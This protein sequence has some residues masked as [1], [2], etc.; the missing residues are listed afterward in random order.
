MSK[1]SPAPSLSSQLAVSGHVDLTTFDSRATTGF[2]GKKADAAKALAAI[3]EEL[4]GLQEK[5]FAGGRSG[6]SPTKVLLVLQ[7]MDTSGK[8]GI[9]R[10]VAG[11]VDPQGLSITSFKKPTATELE[12]DFLWRIENA[13]PE[14]GMIGIFDRSHYE[15]VLIGKVRHLVDDDEISRRY[16]AINDFER[17]FRASG[18]VIVKCFLHITP[19]DQKERLAARLDDPTKYWKY[20]AGDLDERALWD[21]YQDA[22]AVALERCSTGNGAWHVVPSGRKW[23]RN[24][25]V[26]TLLLEQLRALD[27]QWPAADFDVEAEKARLAAM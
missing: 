5:L 19:D 9:V 27:L 3:G 12:H 17:S 13:L 14:P 8:G 25:A 1:S 15:D 24:W 26:A 23:Y 7:G 21:D 10:H 6:A 11:L 16:I 22:Y 4:D 20:N 18:G 2:D